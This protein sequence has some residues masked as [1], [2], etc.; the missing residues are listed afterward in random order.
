LSQKG[1]AD[2]NGNSGKQPRFDMSLDQIKESYLA[3]VVNE[4]D[5][6]EMDLPQSDGQ[7]TVCRFETNR[8]D[9]R[10]SPEAR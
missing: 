8:R 5:F 7:L 10:W 1:Q 6:V 2:G 9:C 4:V 3:I